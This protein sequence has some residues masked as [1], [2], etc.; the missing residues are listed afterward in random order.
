M[1][2]KLIIIGRNVMAVVVVVF[3]IF[4][5]IAAR[6]LCGSHGDGFA[7]IGGRGCRHDGC[8]RYGQ[9]CKR[10]ARASSWRHSTDVG[11]QRYVTCSY[12]TRG[13]VCATTPSARVPRSLRR[14]ASE[15]PPPLPALPRRRLLTP[16]YL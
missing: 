5:S 9:R 10:V 6:M 3:Y 16:L 4:L 15:A 12:R 14:P 8:A 11:W 13:R 2:T 7:I 1:L